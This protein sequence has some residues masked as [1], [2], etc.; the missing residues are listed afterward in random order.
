[1]L[2]M[3]IKKQNNPLSVYDCL[4]IQIY[5]I[6]RCRYIISYHMSTYGANARLRGVLVQNTYQVT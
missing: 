3:L 4:F 6:D 2:A 5:N 1:M